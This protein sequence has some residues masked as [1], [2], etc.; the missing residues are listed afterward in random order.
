[1][2]NIRKNNLYVKIGLFLGGFLVLLFL[3]LYSVPNYVTNL[4]G[5]CILLPKPYKTMLGLPWKTPVCEYTGI[6]WGP[7]V[8]ESLQ[9]WKCTIDE[10]GFCFLYG[11]C[12]DIPCRP[13]DTTGG[14]QTDT[15]KIQKLI[16]QGCQ[17]YSD[18]CNHCYKTKDGYSCTIM[19]CF[20]MHKPSCLD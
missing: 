13:K 18:G 10:K 4:N 17:T 12:G 7:S 1:M 8:L 5:S 9:N 15:V 2:P 11:N 6:V 3:T 14:Y 20:E 16:D 19:G